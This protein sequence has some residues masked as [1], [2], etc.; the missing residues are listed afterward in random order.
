M[1]LHNNTPSTLKFFQKEKYNWDFAVVRQGFY[2]Y[3]KKIENT[4]ELFENRQYITLSEI[5]DSRL[6]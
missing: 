2:D 6:I 5:N 3:N 4:G 1:F